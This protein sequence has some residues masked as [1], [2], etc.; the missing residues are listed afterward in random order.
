MYQFNISIFIEPQIQGEFET[1]FN[2]NILNGISNKSEN[3]L[4][5]FHIESHQEPDSKGYSLQLYHP[6]L[7][8][9]KNQQ[10]I[11]FLIIEKLNEKFINKYL[12]FTSLLKAIE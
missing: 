2:E 11:I 12:Y 9:E 8:I 3:P 7:N 10:E 6:A 1:Y 5:L 4:R